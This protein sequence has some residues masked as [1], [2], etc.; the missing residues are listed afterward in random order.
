MDSQEIQFLQHRLLQLERRER[1][2]MGL[3]LSGVTLII[4]LVTSLNTRAAS[5]SVILRGQ[6]LQILDQKGRPRIELRV[7]NGSPSINLSD[8]TTKAGVS[9]DFI[10]KAPSIAMRDSTGNARA[11]LFLLPEGSPMLLLADAH[12]KVAVTI[13]AIG[14]VGHMDLDNTVTNEFLSVDSGHIAMR[15]DANKHDSL[16]LIGGYSPSL[17]IQDADGYSTTLG[18]TNLPNST[19][20]AVT[21]RTAAS[22]VL[23]DKDGSVI[24]STP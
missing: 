12:R 6:G 19:T 1:V 16:V 8:D 22:V 14:G 21:K 3:I 11:T 24:W 4:A 17:K 15:G 10:D 7:D 23:F 18:S 2:L 9:L 20:G 5:Q 13:S